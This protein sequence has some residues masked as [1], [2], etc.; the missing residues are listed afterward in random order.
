[1]RKTV[2]GIVIGTAVL[3]LTAV[4]AASA[5]T[6]TFQ[7]DGQVITNPVNGNCYRLTGDTGGF[8]RI[9]NS[10]DTT[11]FVSTGASCS[12]PQLATV[13]P[14]ADVATPTAYGSVFFR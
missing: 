10:T 12:G 11:A 14:G 13:T 3:G 1:M 6:G 9:T 4:P 2:V 5:A 8:H 7:Y